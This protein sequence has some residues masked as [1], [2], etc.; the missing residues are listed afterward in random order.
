MRAGSPCDSDLDQA[1]LTV[2]TLPPVVDALSLPAETEVTS[3][4]HIVSTFVVHDIQYHC[5]SFV[6]TQ[7]AQ[8]RCFCLAA[9]WIERFSLRSGRHGSEWHDPQHGLGVCA[10][11][12]R[13]MA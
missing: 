3:T 6:G 5:I 9:F 1:D 10:T 11:G 7:H 4:K 12:E 2:V 13:S 8:L